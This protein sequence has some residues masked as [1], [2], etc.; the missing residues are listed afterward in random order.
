MG[1]PQSF[2]LR[3]QI[4]PNCMFLPYS[5]SGSPAPCRFE[6]VASIYEMEFHC[7]VAP[8]LYR[9]VNENRPKLLADMDEGY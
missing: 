5:F 6:K 2:Q 7:L 3:V 9:F 4:F 1:F 8:V